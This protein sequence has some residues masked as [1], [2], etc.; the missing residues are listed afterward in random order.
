MQILNYFLFIY[1]INFCNSFI[2]FNK[3]YSPN[4][5]SPVHRN[6]LNMGC[7]Y[8]IDKDLHIYDYNNKILLS[9]NLKHKR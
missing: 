6:K 5:I 1:F 2:L 7:N 8:Y 3:K 4:F 9:I